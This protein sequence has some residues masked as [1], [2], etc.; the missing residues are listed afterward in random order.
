[1]ENKTSLF[2]IDERILRLISLDENEIVDPETGEVLIDVFEELEQLEM[3]RKDKILAIGR[4]I[5]GLE[6]EKSMLKEKAKQLTERAKVKEN[7]V[8]YLEEYLVNSMTAFDT[9]KIEDETVT[10]KLNVSKK[11]LPID[12]NL[13][14]E[15]YLRKTLNVELDKRRMLADLKAGKV[16]PGVELG[17][18]KTISVR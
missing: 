7:K 16:I 15:E 8:K 5:D 4:Y 17:E 13:I 3:A 12:E 14:P 10:V 18:S 9:K 1:M 2:E 11:V 6:R